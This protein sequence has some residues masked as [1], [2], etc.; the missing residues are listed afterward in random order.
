MKTIHIY[1][2]LLILIS[3]FGVTAEETQYTQDYLNNACTYLGGFCEIT[4]QKCLSEKVSNQDKCLVDYTIKVMNAQ[5]NPQDPADLRNVKYAQQACNKLGD[6]CSVIQLECLAGGSMLN[7]CI[8]MS[9]FKIEVAKELCGVMGYRACLESDRE[10]GI[11]VIHELTLPNI[12]K[13]IKQKMWEECAEAG[14]YKVKSAEL[15]RF[16]NGY[17]DAFQYAK[18]PILPNEREDYEHQIQ[19]EYYN[20]MKAV[21][22]KSFL[23]NQASAPAHWQDKFNAASQLKT[24]FAFA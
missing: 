8:A 15:K 10:Y 22:D 21:F 14:N 3:A 19:E 13:P 23:T 2:S 9:Y 24:K 12:D 17:M 20:C 4:K 16:Y 5:R 7:T 6:E 11:K 18:E 1:L